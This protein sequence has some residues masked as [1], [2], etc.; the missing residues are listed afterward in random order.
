MGGLARDGLRKS[1]K[2]P[3]WDRAYGCCEH[4]KMNDQDR[5]C[6][7]LLLRPADVPPSCESAEV[8]GVFNPGAA[9]IDGEVVLLVRVAERRPSVARGSWV[10]RAGPAR[11]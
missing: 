11:G 7:Q 10:C 9:E 1:R 5:S 2:T 3:V 4:A 8:I 6:K